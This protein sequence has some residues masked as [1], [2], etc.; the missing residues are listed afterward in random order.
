MVHALLI[1]PPRRRCAT[2]CRFAAFGLPLDMEIAR[3]RLDLAASAKTIDKLGLSTKLLGEVNR[4]LDALGF[5]I[6]RGT[7][8]DATILAGS[9]WRPCRGRRRQSARPRVLKPTRKRDK[10]YFGY[11][12]HLAVDEESGLVRQAEM[13]PANVHDSRLGEALIQGDEQGF[14]DRA[15]DSFVA[16]RETLERRGRVDGIAWK[17]KHARYPLEPWQKLHNARAGSVRSAVERA[18]ATMKRWYGMGR[19]RYL[20]LARNAC[21]LQLVAIAMNMKRASRSCEKLDH[22]RR[23]DDSQTLERPGTASQKRRNLPPPHLQTRYPNLTPSLQGSPC[24][25]CKD[26]RQRS[27][28]KWSG[29]DSFGLACMDDLPMSRRDSVPTFLGRRDGSGYGR[30]GDFWIGLRRR[31]PTGRR[32]RRCFR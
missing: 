4:Q 7:L 14:A 12:A 31:S 6:K 9:V 18:F 5:V 20:G 32:S 16:L 15:Y 13:T 28:Q 23:K 30:V 17:V 2:G 21:H 29:F 19:V 26:L 25:F 10:T 22:V 3:P 1:P 24:F 11:K 27:L 8:V